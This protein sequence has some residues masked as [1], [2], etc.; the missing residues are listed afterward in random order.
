MEDQKALPYCN[1]IIQE[2]QRLA[3]IVTTNFTRKVTAPVNI[4][5]YD[6]PVGTGVIP[7]FNVVHLDENEYERPDFFFP[8]RHIDDKGE[9]VKDLCRTL[10]PSQ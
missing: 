7:E 8:E 2:V 3:N 10:L 6:I 1:A 4:E 9:F 5:G